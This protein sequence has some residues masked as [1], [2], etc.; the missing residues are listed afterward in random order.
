VGVIF[1]SRDGEGGP[2]V[3]QLFGISENLP[4]FQTVKRK[5]KM[6]GLAR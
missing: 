6:F 3:P 2:F 1:P 5:L 4:H